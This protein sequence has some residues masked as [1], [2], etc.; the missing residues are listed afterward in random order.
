M[1]AVTW[2]A[3]IMLANG[4]QQ[5]VTVLAD[6]YFN[7]RMMIEAQFGRGRSA[8]PIGPTKPLWRALLGRPSDLRAAWVGH[9]TDNRPARSDRLP[10]FLGFSPTGL[11]R[12][13]TD[14]AVA[15]RQ[16]ST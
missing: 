3:T 15:R 12:C 16:R 2:Y 5:R 1:A 13:R 11:A 6:N 14:Y 9:N 4:N 10:G 8:M 7:A